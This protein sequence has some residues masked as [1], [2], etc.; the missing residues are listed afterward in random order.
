MD[1]GRRRRRERE[2]K[3]RGRKNGKG[4]KER[5][6][7]GKEKNRRIVENLKATCLKNTRGE[8]AFF[9]FS[10]ACPAR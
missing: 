2:R 9:K 5:R 6:K 4:G 8:L 10:R 7:E 1:E 3:K